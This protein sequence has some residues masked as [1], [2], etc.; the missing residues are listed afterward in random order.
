MYV[1]HLAPHAGVIAVTQTSRSVKADA[2]HLAS[3]SVDSLG[4][5]E[6]ALCVV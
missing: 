4:A 3:L 2:D 1:K 6:D 5:I